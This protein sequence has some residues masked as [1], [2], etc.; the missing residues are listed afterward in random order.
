MANDKNFKVK[1][2]LLAGRYLLSS[3]TATSGSEGYALSNAE[4]D[5]VSELVNARASD[6]Y[7]KADGTKMFVTDNNF[8]TPPTGGINEYTLSTAWDITTRGSA[9]FKGL[10]AACITLWFKDDG[11]RVYYVDN[12]DD[13]LYQ[14]DLSTAWSISTA[15]SSSAS[16]ADAG[17]LYRGSKLSSDGTK[18]YIGARDSNQIREW[19]LSTA[20]DV[21]TANVSA[22]RT[23]TVSGVSLSQ[24]SLAA[25]KDDGTK[26]YVVDT[27]TSVFY[28]F[29]LSTAWDVSTASYD[30]VSFD[31]SSQDGGVFTLFWKDD[32]TKMYITGNDNDTIFQYSTALL[33]QT[34]DLSTGNTFSFTPSGATTVSFTNAPD[35]GTAVG[36][37]VEVNG[38]GSAITWPSSVEWHLGTAPTATAS[39]EL[40]SF[41]TTDGGT[42]VYGR[43][44]AE[45]LA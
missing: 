3:G 37:T 43:K 1:N 35:S 13:T 39:K 29:S 38:D 4:Y 31:V 19:D 9:T 27:A 28:Q 10:S 33:T 26:M 36:F 40:Y 23:Y 8:T 2:G 41:V 18:L 32:G 6:V 21:T 7:F 16:P 12:S 14:A 11:T 45:N 34:L 44:A 30:S 5:S 15:G 17:T 20:W 25:F 24:L 42:T 22:D